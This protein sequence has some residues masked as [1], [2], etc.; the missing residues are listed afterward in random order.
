MNVDVIATRKSERADRVDDVSIVSL[1]ELL[2]RADIVSIHV[3]FSDETR[4]MIDESVLANEAM[5]LSYQLRAQN[6]L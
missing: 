4:D 3:P 6:D 2:T 1:D 5:L